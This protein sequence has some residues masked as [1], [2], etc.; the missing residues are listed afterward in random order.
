VGG[1]GWGVWAPPPPPQPPNPQTPIPNPQSPKM[2]YQGTI[3]LILIYNII[4]EKSFDELDF[5]KNLFYENNGKDDIIVGVAGNKEDL[6]LE[7]NN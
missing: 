5:W 3:I 4:N 1:V 7:K 2:F 6:Y